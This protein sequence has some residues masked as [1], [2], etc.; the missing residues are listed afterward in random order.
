M[1][2]SE[3]AKKLKEI[4]DGLDENHAIR[5][6]RAISW[7]KCT[8]NYSDQDEDVA[9]IA[10]WI[11]FNS[12]Y[13]VDEQ[14][15]IERNERDKFYDFSK[16]LVSFDK[17]N[18]IYNL[19]WKKYSE[20]VRGVIENRYIFMP[21]W[22]SLHDDSVNWKKSF[23]GSRHEYY[24]ALKEN[25]TELLLG[26]ILDRL[27]VLRNQLVH[28]GATYNSKVNRDQIKTGRNLMQELVPL[29][30]EIMFNEADWGT[31]YFPVV[32]QDE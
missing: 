19:L 4:R 9:V 28:G 2:P 24:K 17:D 14:A 3:L 27:Y 30:I 18:R 5:L 25:N 12:C 32:D 7:L 11:A 10:L 29:F 8:N 23:D 20:F 21:F 16:K 1:Q 22:A 6:H 13:A 26:I 31:I 15:Y